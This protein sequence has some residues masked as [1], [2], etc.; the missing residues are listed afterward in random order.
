MSKPSADNKE[1]LN[2]QCE[3]GVEFWSTAL[4]KNTVLCEDQAS[5]DAKLAEVIGLDLEVRSSK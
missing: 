3:A 5:A 4:T 1:L 2:L